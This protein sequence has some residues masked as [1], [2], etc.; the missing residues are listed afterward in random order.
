MPGDTVE[1]EEPN[2]RKIKS[3]PVRVPTFQVASFSP[4]SVTAC[5][6]DPILNLMVCSTLR[7][8]FSEASN[9]RLAVLRSCRQ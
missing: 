4:D 3:T 6:F 7:I 2:K 9:C 5:S 1:P 8:F